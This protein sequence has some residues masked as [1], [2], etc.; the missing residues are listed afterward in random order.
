MADVGLAKPRR[1][2]VRSLE[3]TEPTMSSLLHVVPSHVYAF[4]YQGSCKDVYGRESFFASACLD[5]RKVLVAG[6]DPEGIE[7]ATRQM[8]PGG[9]FLEY[10]NT[11]RVLTFLRRRFPESFIAV[12]AHN[13]EPLQLLANHGLGRDLPRVVYGML[14]LLSAD[15]QCR[16]KANAVYPISEWE[17]KRYWRLLPG[18]AVVQWLP[19]FSASQAAT[20][21]PD[22]ERD[23]I[24]CLAGRIR[25]YPRSRDM[26]LR[27]IRFAAALRRV[28]DRYRYVITGDDVASAGLALPPWMGTPGLVPDIGGFMGSLRAVAMLSPL[29]YGFKTTIVDALSHGSVPLLHPAQLKRVPAIVRGHCV[30]VSSLDPSDLR[31][32]LERIEGVPDAA[33]V[34]ATLRRISCETLSSAFGCAHGTS[35]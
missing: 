26:A 33:H 4:P 31:T 16:R 12:R 29:G 34:N 27:F 5:Y 15:L 19:Y 2:A 17:A 20:A 7:A 22:G 6:D 32:I 8:S 3:M 28:T 11:P 1:A 18:R 9:V 30:G 25:D 21:E 35:A 14:R 23:T 24:A 13:L 10:T